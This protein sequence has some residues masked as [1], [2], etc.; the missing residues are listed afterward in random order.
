MKIT[1]DQQTDGRKDGRTDGRTNTPAYR[2]AGTHLKKKSFHEIT[3]AKKKGKKRK[4]KLGK[5]RIKDSYK[6]D[7]TI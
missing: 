7:E 1:L 6:E 5:R 3:V 4:T 2:D